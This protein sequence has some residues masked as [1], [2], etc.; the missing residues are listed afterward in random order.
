[1]VADELSRRLQAPFIPGRGEYIR[2]SVVTGDVT[3][4]LI[5][6]TTFMNRSGTAVAEALEHLGLTPDAILIVFD[7][8]Q[9]PLGTLR[10]RPQGSDGGHNG[11]GSVIWTLG[12][13]EVP[14]L[15]LGI[16][17]DLMPSGEEKKEFV[18]DPFDPEEFDSARRMVSRAADAALT[19]GTFGIDRAMNVH[20]TQ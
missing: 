5:K 6:P 10:L 17:R 18:L 8:F 3:L 4:H 16:G 11:L 20:N 1:M 14:R 19:F 7:D 13:D 2:A 9:L 15:R 12:T